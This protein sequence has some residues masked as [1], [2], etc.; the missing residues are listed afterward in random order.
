VKINKLLRIFNFPSR[1]IFCYHLGLY[2]V[3]KWRTVEATEDTPLWGCTN[4][5]KCPKLLALTYSHNPKS[6]NYSRSRRCLALVVVF[7]LSLG[8]FVLCAGEAWA[9]EPPPTKAEKGEEGLRPVT[10]AD[11]DN[12][13]GAGPAIVGEPAESMGDKS[14]GDKEPAGSKGPPVD[15]PPSQTPPPKTP[16]P[17]GAEPPVETTT[18]PPVGTTTPPPTT[19][20]P[21]VDT[22]PATPLV[23]DEPTAPILATMPADVAEPT[24]A[25]TAPS[26][27]VQEP[28]GQPQTVSQAPE[29]LDGPEIPDGSSAAGALPPPA[30]PGDADPMVAPP[31]SSEV[32]PSE[33][34]ATL[35]ELLAPVSNAATPS[36]PFSPAANRSGGG[37][38]LGPAFSVSEAWRPLARSLGTTA[39]SN[40]VHSFQSTLGTL[41]GN[42]FAQGS[43]TE[44]PSSSSGTQSPSA[45]TAPPHPLP[46][47]LPI[48]GS[49]SITWPEGGLTGSVGGGPLLLLFGALATG[50]VLLSRK[51]G[52]LWLNLGEVPK[53]SSALLLP[54]ERPG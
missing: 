7:A 23:D 17:G 38:A 1:I 29:P 4:V 37:S 34:D 35:R 26:D 14:M 5:R 49:S 46:P 18:P 28:T 48:G 3:M 9:K 10:T 43:P 22:E 39:A 33:A 11:K 20:P 32:L 42:F 27:S 24:T 16:P 53:P 2:P 21:Q 8:F 25:T 44:T 47:L 19:T 36:V 51:D 12:G 31:P 40:V 13:G 54:L 45:S 52:R 30:P 41:L 50:L 6:Q 15:S